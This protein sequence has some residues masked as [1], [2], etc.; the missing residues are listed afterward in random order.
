MLILLLLPYIAWNK[1]MKKIVKKSFATAT[2]FSMSTIMWNVHLVWL[3]NTGRNMMWDRWQPHMCWARKEQKSLGSSPHLWS[4]T[5]GTAPATWR[6]RSRWGAGCGQTSEPQT[7]AARWSAG[8]EHRW[9]D[10]DFTSTIRPHYTQGRHCQTLRWHCVFLPEGLRHSRA[11]ELPRV[12]RWS[13]SWP[14]VQPRSPISLSSMRLGLPSGCS[15]FREH[16][17]NSSSLWMSDG[18]RH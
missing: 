1:G 4:W 10:L 15:T 7:E 6:R 5:T 9:E 12:W 11:S 16:T 18:Q 2:V 13:M 8:L 3:Q 17:S 14:A